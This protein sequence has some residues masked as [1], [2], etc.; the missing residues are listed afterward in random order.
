MT[1]KDMKATAKLRYHQAESECIIHPL[2][3]NKV[4]LEFEKPQRAVTPGQAAV[5]Y[6]GEYV[7]GG[8]QSRA[9]KRAYRDGKG[10][11][12]DTRKTDSHIGITREVKVNL[13]CVS[14]YTDKATQP[15]VHFT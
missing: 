10:D 14:E 6:D 11:A 1:R 8:G 5:F 2:G 7:L 3:D 15:S 12:E 13:E 9:D 4:L